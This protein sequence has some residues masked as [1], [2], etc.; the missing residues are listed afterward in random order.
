MI[1]P[2][3]TGDDMQRGPWWNGLQR[4]HCKRTA[5]VRCPC[6]EYLGLQDHAIADDGTV[7]PSVVC[8]RCDWHHNLKLEGWKS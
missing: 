7:T 6:G 2:R 8:P 4:L 1:I 3:R 5:M